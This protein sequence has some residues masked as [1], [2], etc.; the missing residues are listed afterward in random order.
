[1]LNS[2]HQRIKSKLSSKSF[3]EKKEETNKVKDTQI[4]NKTTVRKYKRLLLVQGNV[5]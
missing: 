5:T 3:S 4:E 2:L 1:M